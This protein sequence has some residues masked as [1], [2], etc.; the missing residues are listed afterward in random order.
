[1]F[2]PKLRVMIS[3]FGTSPRLR[4][5]LIR[6]GLLTV[7]GIL[8]SLSGPFGT[9]RSGGVIQRFIYWFVLSSVSIS[10]ALS[11]QNLVWKYRSDWHPLLKGGSVIFGT[12]ILFTPFLWMWT[13][14]RYPGPLDD[15]PTVFWMT[16]VVFAIC[17]S[18]SIFRFGMTYF[19]IQPGSTMVDEPKVAR[20][21]RRLPEDFCGKI[22]HLAID[23][24]IVQVITNVGTFDLRMRFSDAVDEVSEITGIC[25]HRSH[26]V[27]LAEIAET[28][29]VKGRP[30]L[31]LS[32]GDMVPVSRKYEPDLGVLGVL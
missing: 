21:V 13:F 26:W 5:L 6:F 15:P 3:R 28:I 7:A 22:V 19:L 23:G 18:A 11:L 27:A 4:T 25:A 12:T 8:L 1:M 9:Y 16:L 24:H 17:V 2:L 30:C 14:Q 20:L 32:N 10:I 29:T 31:V